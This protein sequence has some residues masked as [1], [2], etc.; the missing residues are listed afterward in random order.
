MW[1]II[2]FPD[3][4]GSDISGLNVRD[5]KSSIK[6]PP[7]SEVDAMSILKSPSSKI[8]SPDLKST[9]IKEQNSS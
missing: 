4:V 5:T 2:L 8:L 3:F 7:P 6:S 9:E 1:S